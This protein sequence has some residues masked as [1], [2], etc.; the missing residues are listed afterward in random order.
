MPADVS[1]VGFD[2]IDLA[3]YAEPSLTTVAQDIP[4]LGRWAVDHLLGS[5]AEGPVV[6]GRT[7]IQT[8]RLPVW[9]VAR[10]ST[11]PA[12]SPIRKA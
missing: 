4:F 12:P 11:G 2:D 8:V 9:L 1:V 5:L 10:G 6:A 3:A 7:G